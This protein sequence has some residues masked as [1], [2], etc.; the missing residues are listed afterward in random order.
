MNFYGVQTVGK[1]GLL[2][3]AFIVFWKWH[4]LYLNEVFDGIEMKTNH[5]WYFKKPQKSTKIRKEKI[6]KFSNYPNRKGDFRSFWHF[7]MIETTFDPLAWWQSLS[8]G[9]GQA[10]DKAFPAGH[11]RYEPDDTISMSTNYVKEAFK[12]S[13]ASCL[14][15]FR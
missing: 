11:F 2:I 9:N 4:N 7:K 14:G 12:S 8:S 15:W 10:K 3:L 5:N 13:K 6:Q 1:L